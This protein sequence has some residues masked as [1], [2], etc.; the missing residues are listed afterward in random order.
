MHYSTLQRAMAS[1]HRIFELLDIEI[2][3]KDTENAKDISVKKGKIEFKNVDFE[4][5]FNEPVLKN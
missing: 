5:N 3:I 1:G 2:D 4:Y